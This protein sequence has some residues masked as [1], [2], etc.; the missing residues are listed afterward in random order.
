MQITK[1]NTDRNKII[2]THTWVTFSSSL[3]YSAAATCFDTCVSPSGSSSVSAELYANRMQWLIRL[4]VIRCYVSA[5]WRPGTHWSVHI[6]PPHNRLITTYNAESYQP[7]HSIR[8]CWL[9]IHRTKNQ[10]TKIKKNNYVIVLRKVTSQF[11]RMVSL[12]FTRYTACA[13]F[14]L[15]HGHRLS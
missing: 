13:W 15:Q 14:E 1:Y 3:F 9:Y 7:L 11:F 2:I 5:M 10:G 12:F 4:C 6:S 8:I